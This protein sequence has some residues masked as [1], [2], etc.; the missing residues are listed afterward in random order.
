MPCLFR[1]SGVWPLLSCIGNLV[2]QKTR[3]VKCGVF[4]TGELVSATI[5]VYLRPMSKYIAP[6]SS[7]TSKILQYSILSVIL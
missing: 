3:I 1:D 6:S 2:S 5:T 4:R 7:V